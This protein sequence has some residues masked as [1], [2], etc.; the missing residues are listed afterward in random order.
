MPFFSVI[1]AARNSDAEL[2]N[3][4]PAALQ[5]PGLEHET[6]VKYGDA[7][8]KAS[9]LL[10]APAGAQTPLR[11]VSSKS[12]VSPFVA[13][14]MPTA[15]HSPG[16]VQEIEENADSGSSGDRSPALIDAA[17]TGAQTP[18]VD[19]TVIAFCQPLDG[20]RTPAEVQLPAAEHDT[21]LNSAERTT[22]AVDH[23]PLSEE[24]R[25]PSWPLAHPN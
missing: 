15:V 5:L 3:K 23:V 13:T 14:Y 9:T 21:E 1:D 24:A 20:V 25:K 16:A 12:A 10:G 6:D 19:E 18:F 22:T 2:R 17:T 11:S 8:T 7:S 4:L